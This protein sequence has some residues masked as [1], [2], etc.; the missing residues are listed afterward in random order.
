MIAPTTDTAL[1]TD[2]ALRVLVFAPMGRNADVL[3]RTLIVGGLACTVCKE[4][5]E[6]LK[7]VAGGIAG[8]VLLTEDA[9][10]P[11]TAKALAEILQAQPA[12]S[13][14]PLVVLASSERLMPEAV[15]GSEIVAAL[16]QAANVTLLE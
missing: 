16:R 15:R 5:G 10:T 4:G 3:C 2:P 7:L 8:A 14:L 9:L 11:E 6:L 12:W 1:R 13:D